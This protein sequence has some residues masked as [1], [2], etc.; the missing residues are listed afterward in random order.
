MR[1]FFTALLLGIILLP[2]AHAG[3]KRTRPIYSF[4]RS[5]KINTNRYTRPQWR[6]MRNLYLYRFSSQFERSDYL[7][8]RTLEPRGSSP[9]KIESPISKDFC[10]YSNSI[11][12]EYLPS[13]EVK[14]RCCVCLD[15]WK[16]QY[17]SIA[18]STKQ[19]LCD[20]DWEPPNTGN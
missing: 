18:S 7:Q 6:T 19:H 11:I 14:N 15:G 1:K 13:E 4:E 3:W 10:N 5:E 17:S 9:E 2:S 12:G 8:W 16:C 20:A